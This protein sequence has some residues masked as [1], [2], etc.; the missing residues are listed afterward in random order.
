LTLL[1]Q[2]RP[3]RWSKNRSHAPCTPE[4][5]YEIRNG[6]NV[7]IKTNPWLMAM[8][9]GWSITSRSRITYTVETSRNVNDMTSITPQR[10]PSHVH[11][12]SRHPFWSQHGVWLPD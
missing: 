6:V 9:H 12:C 11:A 7:W 8:K 4:S 2:V 5:K 3:R 1:Q 10:D